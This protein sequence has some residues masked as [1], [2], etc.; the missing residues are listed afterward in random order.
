MRGDYRWRQDGNLVATVWQDSKPV[1][2]LSTNCNPDDITTVR[3]KQK[4]GSIGDVVCP[5]AIATYNQ[6]TGGVDMGNQY[7]GY[8]NV[9]TKS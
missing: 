8:Y 2:V 4:D 1:V 7:R 5:S 6:Y 3:R 9:H